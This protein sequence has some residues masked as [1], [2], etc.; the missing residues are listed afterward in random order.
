MEEEKKKQDKNRSK[1]KRAIKKNP[2]IPPRSIFKNQRMDRF[3]KLVAKNCKKFRN[4][5]N[6]IYST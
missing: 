1:V 4:I 6:K 2:W 3:R 5:S